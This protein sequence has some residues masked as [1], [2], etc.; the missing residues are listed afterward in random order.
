MASSTKYL[1]KYLIYHIPYSTPLRMS[2]EGHVKLRGCMSYIKLNPILLGIKWFFST[3][4]W[5]VVSQYLHIIVLLPYLCVFTF[6][7]QC[8]G[9]RYDF[10]IKTMLGS[11]LPP[12]VMR[13]YNW[14]V[15]EI[16]VTNPIPIIR[17]KFC[18]SNIFSFP[19]DY[20]LSLFLF[21]YCQMI[22]CGAGTAYLGS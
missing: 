11:S 18:I 14:Y 7:V 20:C 5:V 6:W 22:A 3:L 19:S 17:F 16:E 1:H 12:V 21:I 10:R 4:Y 9:V 15:V 8:C 13:Q 2:N